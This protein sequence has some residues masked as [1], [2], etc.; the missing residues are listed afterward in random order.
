[1]HK[2]IKKLLTDNA[3][4]IATLI[5][6]SIAIGSLISSNT[7][8]S[9]SLLASDKTIHFAAYFSLTLSWLYAFFKKKAFQRYVAYLILGCIIFGTVIE[10]LQ[11]MI[12]SDRTPSYL[13]VLANTV[14]ILFAVMI[15]HLFE[16]KLRLL[17][18]KSDEADEKFT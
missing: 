15:F 8:L 12:A 4:Y 5:T 6:I 17:S 16:K 18:V 9:K 1:M 11:M 14:G 13:D 2:T 3:V 10:L 7:T